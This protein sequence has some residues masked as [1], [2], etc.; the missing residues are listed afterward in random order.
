[1]KRK[2]KYRRRRSIRG[3]A[4]AKASAMMS[5]GARIERLLYVRLVELER[6]LDSPTD[7]LWDAYVRTADA[8]L[9][10]RAPRDSGPPIT[11]GTLNERYKR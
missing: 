10:A 2:S 4:H 6:L 11:K 3:W 8:Y 1:M 7:E 9:R 5:M